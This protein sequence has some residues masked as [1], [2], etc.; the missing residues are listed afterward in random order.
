M[1]DSE[2]AGLI[3]LHFFHEKGIDSFQVRVYDTD[4]DIT[5]DEKKKYV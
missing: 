1:N 3:V 2:I 4:I 5:S